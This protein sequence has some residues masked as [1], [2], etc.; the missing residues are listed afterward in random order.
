MSSVLF[1]ACTLSPFFTWATAPK[2][3]TG[4]LCQV[5]DSPRCCFLVKFL[6]GAV[7]TDSPFWQQLLFWLPVFPKQP[8]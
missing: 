7:E 1:P 8:S 2:A 4:P 3:S 5:P 6:S